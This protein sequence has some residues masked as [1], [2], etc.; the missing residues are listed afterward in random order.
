[1]RYIALGCLSLFLFTAPAH[2]EWQEASSDHFVIYGD[3]KEKAL[4]RFAQRLER[5]HAAMAFVYKTAPTKPSPSN[6]VTVFVVDSAADVRKVTGTS[7]RF[8]AGMYIPRAGASVAVIP[9]LRGASQSE[10][11]GETTL[12]HEYAH[13][14][15]TTSLSSRAYPRWFVEGFAEFFAAARFKQDGTLQLG[16]PPYFRALDLV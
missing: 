5:F 9:H 10:L 1:M 4:T 15:M 7:N 12:Y 16:T 8:V 13:H 14:F 6:R 3:E 2:A 11:T